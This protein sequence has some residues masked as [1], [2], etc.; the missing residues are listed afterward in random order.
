[1]GCVSWAG[2]YAFLEKVRRETSRQVY[3]RCKSVLWYFAHFTKQSRRYTKKKVQIF[4]DF[5][6]FSLVSTHIE[7]EDNAK[8]QQQIGELTKRKAGENL[9]H[10]AERHNEKETVQKETE[11]A[12]RI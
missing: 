6:L 2:I 12:K 9:K 7:L 10:N 3:P 1:M 11:C 8:E 4:A 5:S